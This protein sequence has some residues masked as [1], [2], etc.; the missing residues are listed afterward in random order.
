M[1]AVNLQRGGCEHNPQA[2]ITIRLT[3]NILVDNSNQ[4]VAKEHAEFSIRDLDLV[5]MPR[6]KGVS[7]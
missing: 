4:L 1:S 7:V 2:F 5:V 6:V 3:A